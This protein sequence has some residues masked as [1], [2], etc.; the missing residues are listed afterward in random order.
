[1]LTTFIRIVTYSY[2]IF[3]NTF[4]TYWPLMLWPQIF[5]ECFGVEDLTKQAVF[6]SY[7]YILY[8]YGNIVSSIFWPYMVHYVSVR[9]CILIALLAQFIIALLFALV[10]NLYFIMG[11]RFLS[12]I[13]KNS[14]HVGKD[15]IYGFCE[16]KYRQHG[17]A[18]TSLFTFAAVFIGPVVGI[19]MYDY[20]GNSFGRCFLFIAGMYA[21]AIVA[22]VVVF[23][24]IYV[25]PANESTL[26]PSVIEDEERT[27]LVG[28]K[29]K[30]RMGFFEAFKY[31][32]V[33]PTLRGL[34]VLFI[35]SKS[36]N[37]SY[38]II[39]VF[40]IEAA[41]NKEGMG[42]S[43][44][45]LAYINMISL[46]P[47]MSMLL[48]V[49]WL[50]PRYISYKNYLTIILTIYALGV[51]LMPMLKQVIGFLGYEKFYWLVFI[52]QGIIYM[53]NPK[54]YTPSVSY[55]VN[56]ATTKRGRTA[57]NSITAMLFTTLTAVL[58]S[59]IA[60][61]YSNSVHDE[62]W[63]KYKPFNVYL[64]FFILSGLIFLGIILLNKTRLKI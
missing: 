53:V 4:R 22:F 12:G 47:V 2:N 45:T 24:I 54:T 39:S 59:L 62:E 58:M 35:I 9:G 31:I 46:V 41:W 43:P 10:P 52:N 64:T 3:I 57:V 11:L 23:Y 55:L 42:I 8:Y 16:D 56:K 17:Y 1:M 38:T 18:F 40:F 37:K 30:S 25:P 19:Y 28:K 48:I 50:V 44:M 14:N 6:A 7:Y 60:P 26:Y 5:R 61:L 32:W 51:A 27:K 13:F 21:V 20:S 15:F 36:V 34:T 29:K 49:P 63:I 33:H